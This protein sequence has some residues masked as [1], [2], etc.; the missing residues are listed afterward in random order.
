L[1]TKK[2]YV[3]GIEKPIDEICLNKKCKSCMCEYKKRWYQANKS[4]IRKKQEV[5]REANKEH[6]RAADKLW[7]K[8]NKEK[9]RARTAKWA[10][11]NPDRRAEA[12]QRRR[13]RKRGSQVMRITPEMLKDRLLVF[14]NKCAYCGGPFEHWDHLKP[15]ELQGPHILANLRP[16]CA[17]CNISKGTMIP[18]E[19][20]AICKSIID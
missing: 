3:C 4:K 18:K 7:R 20:L 17:D 13:A 9:D 14:G 16:S 19:W 11:D 5:Y 10:K 6:L 12:E 15:L 1:N 8:N 2:C